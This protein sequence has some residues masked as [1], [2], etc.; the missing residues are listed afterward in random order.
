MIEW[1]SF[2]LLMENVPLRCSDDLGGYEVVWSSS[3]EVVVMCSM[4]H[5]KW[6][7]GSFHSELGSTMPGMIIIS[8]C[9]KETTVGYLLFFRRVGS[10]TRYFWMKSTIIRLVMLEAKVDRRTNCNCGWLFIIVWVWI[11]LDCI[12]LKLCDRVWFYKP[13]R[14]KLKLIY[15]LILHNISDLYTQYLKDSGFR[16]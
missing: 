8:N 13:Y 10:D 12:W 14:C 5:R 6:S 11:G 3:A 16:C 1:E 7:R 9:S 4:G 2:M 15:L